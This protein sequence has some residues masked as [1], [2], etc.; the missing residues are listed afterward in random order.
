VR[1]EGGTQ[2][3]VGGREVAGDGA[4]REGGDEEEC[5]VL[6]FGLVFGLGLGFVGGRVG[7]ARVRV[8]WRRGARS[9][10]FVVDA[11]GGDGRIGT[12]G[13]SAAAGAARGDF[14]GRPRGCGFG[15]GDSFA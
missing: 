6:V 7:E 4:G 5:C 9:L 10:R 13:W 3:G 1:V 15:F 14:R 2:V 8:L 12:F 11:C